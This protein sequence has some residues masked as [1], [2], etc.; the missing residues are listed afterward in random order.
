MKRF[1]IFLFLSLFVLSLALS[2]CGSGLRKP[3]PRDES[4]REEGPRNIVSTDTGSSNMPN[5][6]PDERN[7]PV[8]AKA[9]DK[10]IITVWSWDRDLP[11]ILEKFKELHPDFGYEIKVRDFS[12]HET[13]FQVLL[14]QGL[15]AGGPDAPDIYDVESSYVVKYTQGDACHYAS[16]YSDLG[17]DVD[18]LLN[19]AS[20]A[21]YIVE[22]GTNPEGKVVALGYQSTAGVFIYRRSIAKAVWGTDDPAVIK[23]AAGP[24]WDKFLK[25]AADLK[26][27]GYRICSSVDDVWQAM[28][29]NA[30]KGW[31]VDGKL[32]IDPKREE[33]MDFAKILRQK[34][35]LNN[36][37]S[38]T[39]A[40]YSDM[41]DGGGK[42]VFGFLG[43]SWLLNYILLPGSGGNAP[44]EGTYGDW[45]LCEPPAGFDWGG[46]WVLANKDTRVKEGVA[47]ILR[48]ITLDTSE[49]GLQYLWAN[50]KLGFHVRDAVASAAVM[51]KSDGKH[52]FLGGQNPFG[53]YISA[54]D[55][56]NGK[57]RALQNEAIR[58]KWL[59]QV[60][61]YIDGKKTREQA[62][63]D[64]KKQVA[65]E[66]DITVE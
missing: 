54:G 9:P 3:D 10:K 42:K 39:D 41:K 34:G 8:A 16:A 53:V 33:F 55:M 7:D 40:W 66:L 1:I 28:E 46:T 20:I 5:V 50:D 43:P 2:A 32:Y 30:D 4:S 58:Y 60:H 63:A 64:F 17:I 11:I 14:D 51:K 37:R 36:S 27:K 59:E 65:N 13:G 21:N 29:Q 49:A 56:T 62:S 19:E 18:N 31:I 6:T 35:Y 22:L 12:N 57:N 47:E 25:A 44:G 24:G 48:W 26:A 23:N 38:W 52:D 45:A 15:A 61:E